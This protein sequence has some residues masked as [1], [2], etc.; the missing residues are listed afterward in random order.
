MNL[1]RNVLA[2]GLVSLLTDAS[3]EMIVPLLP[4]FLSTVV[5]GGALA[6][7][8]VE[9][10]A[11]G[12]AAALKLWSGREADRLGRNRPFVV[13]GYT[14]SSVARPLIALATGPVAVLLV[15]VTDRVGKGLRTSPRDAILAGSVPP[16]E[17]GRAFGF[18]RGMDHLG[19]AIGPLLAVGVLT[20][21]SEDLRVVFGLAAIPAALAVAVVWGGV[22]EVEPAARPS[23]EA[24]ADPEPEPGALFPVLAPI[25]LFALANASD[26]FLLLRAGHDD[27]DPRALPLLWMAL[28]LVKSAAQGPGGWLVDRFGPRPSLALGFGMHAACYAALAWLDDP[29][30]VVGVVLIYG[31]RPGLSEPAEKVWVAAVSGKKK[32]TAFGWYNA[33]IGLA[34]VVASVGFGALWAVGD[35]ELAFGVGAA[36]AAASAAAVVALRR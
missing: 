15:R 24:P 5:G 31:L 26:T 32:G 1:Q 9:G 18:H 36:I 11:D 25:T 10:L 13:A 29:T 35:H 7:G 4:L 28:H 3:S 34:A 16:E 2:L 22:T 20:F 14:L 23:A 12:V 19:A 17:R 27:L 30:L 33:A 21:V 8:L 6:L